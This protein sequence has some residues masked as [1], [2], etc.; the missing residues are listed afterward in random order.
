MITNHSL[1]TAMQ[2]QLA[3]AQL[4]HPKTMLLTH[5]ISL[6]LSYKK[7]Y[8]HAGIKKK[9]LHRK[10]LLTSPNLHKHVPQPKKAL[11]N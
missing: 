5:M 2:I 7:Q 4:I 6:L 1:F 10:C 11:K 3:I 9:T 8:D